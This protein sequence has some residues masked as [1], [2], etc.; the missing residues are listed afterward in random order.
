LGSDYGTT[1]L[2]PSS[3]WS[4]RDDSTAHLIFEGIGAGTGELAVVIQDQNGWEIAEGSGTWIKLIDVRSMY[5]RARIVNEAEQI[6]DPW[7]NDN[8]PPQQWVWDPWDWSYSEDPDAENVTAVFVHG[9][10][11]TYM[12]FMGWSDS[13]YKRLWHQGFKGKFYSFRWATFS[14]SL[15]TYNDSE[16]RAWLCGPALATFVNQLPNPGR[17]SLYAH[18]MGNVITGCALRHGM[19]VQHYGLCNAAMASMAYDPNPALNIDPDTGNEWGYIFAGLPPHKT[20]DTDPVLAIRDSYGIK[21]KFNSGTV[22]RKF[23]LGLPDDSALNTW[24]DNNLLF[25]PDASGHNYYQ[26]QADTTTII[27]MFHNHQ[28]LHTN[29]FKLLPL[30]IHEK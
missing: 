27:K 2:I 29:C 3:Y 25:K 5:Q 22:P 1:V 4:L 15:F 7:N 20:P 16:Y 23:N 10:R 21:D 6:P 8:P 17:R 9:W 28:I 30:V 11:L 19:S 14:P 12:E 18:S 26:T 24:V 13:S